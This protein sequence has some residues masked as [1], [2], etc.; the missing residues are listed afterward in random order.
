M[1]ACSAARLQPDNPVPSRRYDLGIH[2]H[3][4]C[5]SV[6]HSPCDLHTRCCACSRCCF[7]GRL[8][9]LRTLPRSNRVPQSVPSMGEYADSPARFHFLVS[10]FS[11]SQSRLCDA[12][13]AETT[14]NACRSLTIRAF[15]ASHMH[16]PDPPPPLS[17]GG[18]VCMCAG[19]LLAAPDRPVRLIFLHHAA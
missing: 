14:A 17:R 4:D 1:P 6:W 18:S 3:G 9:S 10:I 2:L 12:G 13:T 15:V 8:P 7:V 11:R 5:A 19:A 16:R